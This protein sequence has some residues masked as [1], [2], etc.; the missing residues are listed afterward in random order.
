M[1]VFLVILSCKKVKSNKIYI[2]SIDA[3][4]MLVFSSAVKHIY[5][6]KLLRFANSVS[7]E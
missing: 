2:L 6:G 5:I 3:K 4:P 1:F 7:Y